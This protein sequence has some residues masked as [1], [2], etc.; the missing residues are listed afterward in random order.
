[1]AD[2]SCLIAPRKLVI[3]AGLKDENFPIAGTE[4][5][6]SKIQEIYKA[7]G[8]ENNCAL[9]V[10]DKGHYNYADLIWEK[11]YEMGVRTENGNKE[12]FS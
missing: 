5:T 1:M 7:A 11:L 4:K 9:V 6:F 2:L 10:G 8:A 12:T 3:A